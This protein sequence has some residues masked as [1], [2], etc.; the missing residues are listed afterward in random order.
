MKLV[1]EF[2]ASG[3]VAG[4]IYSKWSRFVVFQ[5]KPLKIEICDLET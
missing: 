4:C 5:P 2:N 1:I 3:G